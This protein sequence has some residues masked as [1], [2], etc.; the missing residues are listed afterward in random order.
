M[1][2]LLVQC[3]R[4]EPPRSRRDS[5]LQSLRLCPRSAVEEPQPHAQA[6]ELLVF[7]ILK[8]L[9]LLC[10]RQSRV[11]VRF[12]PSSATRVQSTLFAGNVCDLGPS[13]V[14][15]LQVPVLGMLK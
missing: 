8:H 3:L 6:G 9:S 10:Q 12:I 2:V 5:A 13:G 1:S 14:D 7:L 4:Q 11:R 15:V